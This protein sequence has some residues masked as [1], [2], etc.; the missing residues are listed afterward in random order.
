MSSAERTA[1]VSARVAAVVLAAG[2]STRMGRNKMLLDL[3]GQTVVRRTVRAAIDA[4]VDRVVVVLGHEAERVRAELAGL[5]C[6]CLVNP[7][8]AMGVGTSLHTGLRHVAGLAP[9]AS[10]VPDASTAPD[11][12]NPPASLS[13]DAAVV[14]LADMPFVTADMIA[15]V[16]ERHRAT[17][18]RLVLSHYGDVQAPPTLY[19]RELFAEVLAVPDEKCGKQVVKRHREE[20]VIAAW[21]ESALRDIDVAADYETIRTELA[22]GA[23]RSGS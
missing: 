2:S 23:A 18:A 12:S 10:K 4:G 14:I 5:A 21:P 15:A 1:P 6:E 17:G 16:V 9:D 3:N 19:A 13:V 8:H 22:A 11:A 7:D 20:A